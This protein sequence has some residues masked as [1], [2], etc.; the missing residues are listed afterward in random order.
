MR[1]QAYTDVTE[2]ITRGKLAEKQLDKLV[3]TVETP[4]PEITIVLRHT[5]VE[6]IPANKL[7]KLGKNILPWIY[8]RILGR[9][10]YKSFQI[11]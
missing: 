1:F 3:P 5:F 8:S 11:K 9:K 7:Q 4:C 6:F 2:R 10:I